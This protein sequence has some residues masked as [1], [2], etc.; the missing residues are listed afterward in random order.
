MKK[1]FIA[2][3]FLS[4]FG[5]SNTSTTQQT[6]ASKPNI[7]FIMADDLGS[8]ELG[9]YGNTFNETPHLDRLAGEGARFTQAYTAAPIC[10]PS[11]AAFMTG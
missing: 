6:P 3:F 11:R 8:A 2:A 10:S 9:S 5:C 7:I 1:I 4:L